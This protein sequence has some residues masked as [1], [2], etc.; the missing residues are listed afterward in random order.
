M[1]AGPTQV[2]HA[3]PMAAPAPALNRR[4]RRQAGRQKH[5]QHGKVISIR[6]EGEL[7][8]VAASSSVHMWSADRSPW[9]EVYA[10]AWPSPS[11]KC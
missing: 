10:A 3:G 6:L 11:M 4:F 9:Q 7:N 5:R 2:P 8:P 1:H